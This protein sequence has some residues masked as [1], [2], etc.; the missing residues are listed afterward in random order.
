M[1]KKNQISLEFVSDLKYT[2]F[3]VLVFSNIKK[4]LNIE[5]DTF[6]KIE[7]SLREVVNNAI[8]HGNKSDTGKRVYVT[9]SWTRSRITLSVKDENQERLNVAEIHKRLENPDLLSFSGR[10]IMIMK[11]YMDKVKFVPTRNGNEIILE[12]KI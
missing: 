1:T 6:F 12:K 11:S 7:I 5:D 4:V 2:E 8:I 10:G 9:F 3:C